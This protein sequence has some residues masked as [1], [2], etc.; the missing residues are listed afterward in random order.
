VRDGATTATAGAAGRRPWR[1]LAEVVGFAVVF[2]FLVDLSWRFLDA[3]GRPIYWFPEGLAAG[4]LLRTRHRRWPALLAVIPVSLLV[5]GALGYPGARHPPLAIALV[6][7]LENAAVPL[8]VAWGLERALG[9]SVTLTRTWEVVALV[10]AS[11]LIVPLVG[12]AI[13]LPVWW[14]WPDGRTAGSFFDVILGYTT[15][16]STPVLAMVPVIVTWRRGLSPP[17][18]R[19]SW[20]ALAWTLPLV[21]VLTLV[22]FFAPGGAVRFIALSIAAFPVLGWVAARAGVPAAAQGAFALSVLGTLLTIAGR[23]PFGD[24]SFGL[25]RLVL[26]QG[27]YAVATA[28]A[29]IVATEAGTAR[30]HAATREETLAL[31]D[32]LTG[33][34]PV[35]IYVVDRELRYVRINE[36]QARIVGRAPAELPGR[37]IAEVAPEVSRQVGP[38][39]KR[40]LATGQPVTDVEVTRHD[41]TGPPRIFLGSYYPIRVAGGPIVGVGALVLDITDRK[42]QEQEMARLYREARDAIRVRD[43]FLSIASHELKTPLTP[44][45]TRLQ[46][47]RR[48][49]AQGRPLDVATADKA[50]ASLNK[51]T[52]L[53]NDLLDASRVERGGLVVHPAPLDLRAVVREAIDGAI[54]DPDRHRILL[55]LPDAPTWV[56][57]DGPRLAQVVEN[58]ASNAVK[59]SPRGGPVRIRVADRGE[60]A[61]LSVADEGIGIPGDELPLLFGRFFRARNASAT[62]Y[63]GLGLGLYISQDIVARHGGRIW[64]ESEVGRGST[65]HVALPRLRP[66]AEAGGIRHPGAAA[67]EPASSGPVLSS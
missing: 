30:A 8:A 64:A 41:S 10:L 6:W 60:E 62:A 26:V 12:A 54:P 45:S 33:S 14:L 15:V 3:A 66:G 27:F 32:T 49:I 5:A 46:W 42:R 34:A 1:E 44:L 65:F 48:Q 36:A 52:G 9:R 4:V 22:A 28:S 23:G 39:L 2:L 67:P 38:V 16:Y 24:P 43:D 29:L 50:I 59:Y 7:A 25:D 53:I 20:L 40:V 37:P 57:G 58:L 35:G 55:E 51:L 63:G 61:L 56:D 47:L 11:L 21:G 31:L 19:R 17:L 18:P 13:E